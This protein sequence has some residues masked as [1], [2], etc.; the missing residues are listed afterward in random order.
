MIGR[1]IPRIL[2]SDLSEYDIKL[3][4][5]WNTGGEPE[6]ISVTAH[7]C[8]HS[9]KVLCNVNSSAQLVLNAV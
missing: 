4:H 9:M 8:Q 5:S 7:Y 3:V 2:Q 6:L 1:Y